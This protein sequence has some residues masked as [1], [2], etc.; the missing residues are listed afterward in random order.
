MRPV[1]SA[2]ENGDRPA[3]RWRDSREGG[4]QHE[5]RGGHGPPGCAQRPGARR[6]GSRRGT[7]VK[8]CKEAAT[9]RGQVVRGNTDGE[10]F[11]PF[12]SPLRKQ[13]L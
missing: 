13:C 3:R 8:S 5:E 1:K 12:S 2:N 10:G 4:D 9:D 7:E 11:L 6:P